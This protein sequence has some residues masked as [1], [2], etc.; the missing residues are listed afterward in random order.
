MQQADYHR[1]R[2]TPRMQESV[3]LIYENIFFES[4]HFLI[5]DIFFELITIIM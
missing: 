4:E 3:F 1:H 5:Y 2:P